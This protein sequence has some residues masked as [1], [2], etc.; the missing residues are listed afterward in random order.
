A[1]VDQTGRVTAVSA[2]TTTITATGYATEAGPGS[3]SKTGAMSLRVVATPP[4]WN[5]ADATGGQFTVNGL[6]DGSYRL[7]ETTPP[8]G[9]AAD[10]TCYTFTLSAGE[11]TAS[12]IPKTNAINTITNVPTTVTWSKVD[13]DDT[14]TKLDGSAWKITSQDG[15]SV[16]CVADGGTTDS[17]VTNCTTSGSGKVLADDDAEKGVIKVTGLPAGTYTLNEV[18]AP[19]GYE[20]SKDPYTMVVSGTASKKS[21][22]GDSDTIPNS[23]T[24]GRVSWAKYDETAQSDGTHQALTG[25]RW[26]LFSCGSD[27]TSPS[28]TACTE[29]VQTFDGKSSSRF[30]Y[31]SLL[32]NTYYLLVETKAPDGYLLGDAPYYAVIAT[33]SSSSGAWGTVTALSKDPAVQGQVGAQESNGA[34]PIYNR[35]AATAKWKKTE[36]G[37][38]TALEGSE[39]TLTQYAD[40]TASS[41]LRVYTITYTAP[42]GTASQGSYDISCTVGTDPDNPCSARYDVTLRVTSPEGASA[43]S[44]FSVSGLPWGYYVLAETKAP[45]GHVT[46]AAIAGK[47]VDDSTAGSDFTI[48]YGTVTNEATITSLPMTGGVWTPRLVLTIGAGLLALSVASY[49]LARRSAWRG[50]HRR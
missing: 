41:A 38:G 33:G 36:Y 44:E 7:C 46:G 40:A 39:W 6:P 1:T 25:S 45:A 22:V 13:A 48:D 50:R 49:A 17:A 9:Y 32:L 28:T 34:Y 18:Q 14:K 43:L 20:L 4:Y 12:T 24:Y 35:K 21:T 16:W 29:S 26:E 5:D 27:V 42:K 47:T 19:K 8:S 11:V 15:K 3:G 30:E 10:G 2:G 23:K 31:D 37:S